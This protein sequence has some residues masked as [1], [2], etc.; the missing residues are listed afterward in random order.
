VLKDVEVGVRGQ[1]KVSALAKDLADKFAADKKPP[2]PPIQEPRPVSFESA[3]LSFAHINSA[4]YPLWKV[5]ILII[6][7]R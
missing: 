2:P 5:I 3:R 7:I 1:N 6:I 4:F